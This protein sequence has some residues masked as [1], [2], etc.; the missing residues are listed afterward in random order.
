MKAGPDRRSAVPFNR[1]YTTGAEL[2]YI[3]EA[4]EGAHLSGNGP[5]QRQCSDCS[6]AC[7]APTASC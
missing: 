3:E 4:I 6:R 1:P 5:V 2:R 7:S